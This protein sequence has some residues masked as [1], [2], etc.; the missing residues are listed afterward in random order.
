MLICIFLYQ[1]ELTSIAYESFWRNTA[2][3]SWD[4]LPMTAD[5]KNHKYLDINP[6]GILLQEAQD[7]AE[8]LAIMLRIYNEQRSVVKEF[9]RYL[10]HLNGEFRHE[11]SDNALI[12]RLLD[13]LEDKNG[14][15]GRSRSRHGGGPSRDPLLEDTIYEAEILLEQFNNRQAEIQDLE[16]SAM[17]TCRQLE[18]LL[19]LKQQQASI[20]EAKAALRR[21]DE[22]VKQ[23]RAIMAFTIVTIFFVGVHPLPFLSF[24]IR[25][26]GEIPNFRLFLPSYL[27]VSLPPSSA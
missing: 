12:Y 20:V 23:G 15:G 5:K 21:A 11:Q 19:S 4:M 24:F 3:H 16:D 18:G 14:Q 10:G 8:E 7:I 1:T 22:S 26:S 17:R 6:E 25:D 13:A 27:S 2:L 9:R